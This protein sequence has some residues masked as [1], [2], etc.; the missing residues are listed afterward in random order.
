MEQASSAEMES[1]PKHDMASCFAPT[2]I[3]IVKYWGKDVKRGGNTP[4]NSSCSLTLDPFDL[5]A[6]T[7]IV[8]SPAF[9][10]DELYLNGKKAPTLG[11]S[12][13]AKRLRLCLKTMREKCRDP[14]PCTSSAK[15]AEELRSW[16]VRVAS[17]NTFP[18]AAGLASSAAGYAALVT[19]AATLYGVRESFDGELSTVARRGS[20]SACR[21][22][23][24]GLVAWHKGAA[25]ATS[26]DDSRAE[27]FFDEAHWPELRVAVLVA[28]AKEKETPSADGMTLS[29]ET[30][31]FLG[32]RAASVA[33]PRIAALRSAFE[34]K[35]FEKFADI[36]MRDS[37]SF[38]ATCLDTFPP[39][40]YMDHT[41]RAVIR[42]VH[43]FND[44][45]KEVRVAYTF[46]AGPNAVL[47]CKS[48]RA[49]DEVAALAATLFTDTNDDGVASNRPEHLKRCL[50]QY[51]PAP[52]LVALCGGKRYLYA[53]LK[54]IYFTRIGQG[55]SSPLAPDAAAALIDP[56]TLEPVLDTSNSEKR[57]KKH[58]KT[59][60]GSGAAAVLA[61]GLVMGV[62]LS[63]FAKTTRLPRS[64]WSQ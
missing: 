29:V 4:I 32:Y 8:A 18:T 3:A 7:V 14:V 33:E 54:M 15:D 1:P 21:S 58:R 23:Y 37:N 63:V 60:R 55:A 57:S 20:G 34:D 28:N 17:Q 47:F 59:P 35:D 31:P 38:H 16:K 36:C 9:V 12:T 42:A 22:L 53:D 46:D 10:E 27:Q 56:N 19:A 49:A 11:N 41:S 26:T 25:E 5:R 30:S 51:P 64:F 50:N 62:L 45:H 44:F 61:A 43:A 48:A 52:N 2:N 6:E 24:G 13:H 39:I 40:F